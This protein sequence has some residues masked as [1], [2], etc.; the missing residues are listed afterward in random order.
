MHGAS[1]ARASCLLPAAMAGQELGA[2][3]QESGELWQELGVVGQKSGA[4][5]QELGALGQER[6]MPTGEEAGI[7]LVA[8]T[9]LISGAS[10]LK[11]QGF[12]SEEELK[13]GVLDA[14]FNGLWMS[15]FSS[16]GVACSELNS[17]L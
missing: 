11:A 1:P 4:L 6:E 17:I 5:Q 3:G 2:L 14:W 12:P 16:F 13:V 10:L 15:T 9:V 7:C 8:G